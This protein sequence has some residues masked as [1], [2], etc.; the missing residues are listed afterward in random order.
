MTPLHSRLSR[1]LFPLAAIALFV[2]VTALA[3]SELPETGRAA[4]D[5]ASRAVNAR[6]VEVQQRL[7]EADSVVRAQG[8]SRGDMARIYLTWDAPYGQRRAR[9]THA[10]RCGEADST[11]GD[12]LYL[13]CR[14][15]R[16][17][18]GF[19]AFTAE[20]RVHA[21]IGDTLGDWWRM[22]RGGANAG[23]VVVE[24][25]PTP[26]L[27]GRQPWGTAGRGAALLQRRAGETQ[28]KLIYAVPYDEGVPARADSIYT[29]GRVI[30][31]HRRTLPGCERPVCIEWMSA[32]LAYGLRD[33]PEVTMGERFVAWN[34]PDGSV[35]APFR[36]R[37]TA[38]AWKPAVR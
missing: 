11:R 18:R 33:E 15:G 30:F 4:S 19:N 20:L 21:A 23:S 14:L 5:S 37:G 24:Y 32:T 26:P 38:R 1:T 27:P 12:T 36:A 29:L 22:E 35:C 2:A 9:S 16:P 17:S 28:L 31:R 34:S 10:A 7:A 3:Q 8:G 6:K 13:S 25:G